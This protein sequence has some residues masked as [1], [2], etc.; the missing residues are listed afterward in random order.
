[1]VPK[2]LRDGGKR[3]EHGGLGKNS[4]IP[5]LQV[6]VPKELGGTGR[7]G[8]K[9]SRFFSWDSH[10]VVATGNSGIRTPAM[11][12]KCFSLENQRIPCGN[13]DKNP[14]WIFPSP[15]GGIS[16]GLW[17][18]MELLRLF[19]AKWFHDS[20]ILAASVAPDANFPPHSQDPGH[21]RCVSSLWALPWFSRGD[22]TSLCSSLF[23][24]REIKLRNYEPED[25]E[26]K[27]RKLP[28]GKPASGGNKREQRLGKLQSLQ[29]GRSRGLC[30]AGQPLPG[31]T[32]HSQQRILIPAGER[33][34]GQEEELA[35]AVGSAKQEGSD[36]D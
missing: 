24:P 27:K 12:T 23:F 10:K 1:M 5:Q 3:N 28:P 8:I 25:E 19:Q 22:F 32:S 35:S 21:P 33:L 4:A 36:S 6:F 18:I 31:V 14:L 26:L 34:K 30:P 7:Q 11:G 15:Q 17:G 9:S 20:L 29:G 13:R 16:A 2:H